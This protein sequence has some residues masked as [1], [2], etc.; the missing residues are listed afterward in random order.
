[1]TTLPNKR[2]EGGFTLIELSIVLV[3]IGLIVGGV[4]V[5]QDLIAAAEVRSQMSQVEKSNTAVNTFRT[6]FNGVPGDFSNEGTF[7]FTARA[8][9]NARGDGDGLIEA[10]AGDQC[11]ETFFF[12]SDLNIAGLLDGG[13]TVL[14]D[15]DGLACLKGNTWAQGIY[16]PAGKMGGSFLVYST[17]G[18]NYYY[19]SNITAVGVTGAATEG[20]LIKNQQAYNIDVKMDD[21]IPGTGSVQAMTDMSTV[22]VTASTCIGASNA[23]YDVGSAAA[24]SSSECQLRFQAQF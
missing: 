19:L 24:Q 20:A 4:L 14:A 9:S 23:V 21:G 16:T 1:M 8:N 22:N 13:V 12:W 10:I 17:G 5:G 6:K 11:T 7:G 3:I 2:R 18:R 15:D